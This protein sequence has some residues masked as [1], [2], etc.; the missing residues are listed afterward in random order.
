MLSETRP[1]AAEPV[2]VPGKEG[3]NP[4]SFDFEPNLGC[5]VWAVKRT[6]RFFFRPHRLDGR[7]EP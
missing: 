2:S 4:E 1:A 6:A 7:K 3:K 5:V